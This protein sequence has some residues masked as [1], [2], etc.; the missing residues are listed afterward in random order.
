MAPEI[1]LRKPYNGPSVDIFA[2]G[3]ILFNMMA[4]MAPFMDATEKDPYYRLIW[5]SKYESYWKAV[6]RGHS[7]EFFSAEFKDFVN[8]ILSA[9]PSQRLTLA[10][11][12]SHPW[13]NGVQAEIQ[14]IKE[15]FLDRKMK[16]REELK[17]EKEAVKKHK[18]QVER[19]KE[20][21]DVFS[22][23]RPYRDLETMVSESI[24]QSPIKPEYCID[25]KRA[26][27]DYNEAEP[28]QLNKSM[29]LVIH[30]DKLFRYVVVL[31]Q[32]VFCK[33]KVSPTTYKIKG[34]YAGDIHKIEFTIT[35]TKIDE[36]M[37]CLQ[38]KRNSGDYIEFHKVLDEQFKQP[39]NKMLAKVAE[40]EKVKA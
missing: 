36:F 28:E 17:K 22:G 10:Q 29:N 37:C 16:I 39:I 4:G 31:G 24:Q 27:E 9:N 19:V 30:Y 7:S 34:S 14:A 1:Y 35:I 12:K 2:C 32:K 38:F 40:M 20:A 26:I 23:F 15:E 21:H 3:V 13:Y 5:S 11:V 6:S 8:L 18:E 33:M 25:N